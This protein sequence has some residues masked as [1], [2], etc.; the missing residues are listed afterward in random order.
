M[1]I[2][3]H[4]TATYVAARIAG[5]SF[6]DASK[7]AYAA[8]YVDDATN[9]GIVQFE[10]NNS[11]YFRIAS[12]HR[13][14]DYNNFIDVE[15]HLAWIPFHF[16]PGNDS[17][18]AGHA[19]GDTLSRLVCRP[20]SHVAR[21]ML[22]RA[23]L[24]RDHPRALYRLGI[25][26]HVY[27][28][29]FAHQGFVGAL[30]I[31]NQANSLTCG[32]SELDRRIHESSKQELGV[33][34]IG[35]IKQGI[36]VFLKLI[37]LVWHEKKWPTEFISNF[38]HKSPVGHAAAD[39]YPD[40]PYLKWR[41]VDYRGV[42]VERDNPAIFIQAMEMMVRAMRAWRAGDTS[43]DLDKHQGIASEDRAASERLFSNATNIDGEERR[44]IWLQAIG[45]GQFSFGSELP[46]YI[47]KGAG[48]WKEQ[49]LGTKKKTDTGVE[50][51]PYSASFLASDWKLFHDALQIHRSDIIHEILPRYGICAA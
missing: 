37:R 14:I 19:T 2:D 6:A 51:Y 9:P 46:S 30:S 23:M 49:A 24:D 44:Q 32:D 33:A 38:L 10:D 11:L 45:S 7:I 31:A 1:Q 18:P 16:L 15:N 4:H 5:F 40:Q 39:V 22:R 50:R 42:T 43:M 20:D 21:D 13:M 12:A 29:T 36:Q 17:L 8:Q 25:T 27:A 28:D 47:G 48:S 41:Y 34:L 35:N 26:M 3:G